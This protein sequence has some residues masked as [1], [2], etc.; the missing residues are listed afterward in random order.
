[1]LSPH[2]YSTLVL[3]KHSSQAI[4]LAR[5]EIHAL[6]RRGLVAIDSGDTSMRVTALGDRL[7]EALSPVSWFQRF[8]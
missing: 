5:E 4:D 1:M 8:D 6:V 7:L 2:E 3:I